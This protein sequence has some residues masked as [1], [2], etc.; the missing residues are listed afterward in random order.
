MSV[1]KMRAKGIELND[2]DKENFIGE[3]KKRGYATASTPYT[4]LKKVLAADRSV[5]RMTRNMKWILEFLRHISP[6]LNSRSKQ[7][8]E[9]KHLLLKL[10]PDSRHAAIE[11]AMK[12]S[13]QEYTENRDAQHVKLIQRL[14]NII[15]INEDD[16]L[17]FVN[18]LKDSDDLLSKI[19]L[20]QVSTGRRLIDILEVANI[21]KLVNGKLAFTELSKNK[22]SVNAL[23]PFHFI[24]YADLIK[25]WKSVRASIK[26]DIKGLNNQEIDQKFNDKLKFK[27]RKM[28]NVPRSFKIATHFLRKLYVIYSL[29]FK[30]PKYADMAYIA[31]ILGYNKS[32]ITSVGNYSNIQLGD[33]TDFGKLSEP[34]TTENKTS[35]RMKQTINEMR[36]NGDKITSATVKKK[37]QFGGS[38]MNKYYMKAKMNT[39]D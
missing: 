11:K 31:E 23:T 37:G 20:L 12:L 14:T 1:A 22:K 16:L 13:K 10:Y 4:T 35:L 2:F 15:T 38:S 7:V 8:W 32:V 3:L 34:L 39:V 26:K 29:K 30:P 6:N 27:I 18:G 25:M 33:K 9:I 5:R 19:L 21:P 36:K 17:R 24:G 28:W